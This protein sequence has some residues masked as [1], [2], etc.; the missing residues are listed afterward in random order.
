VGRLPEEEL[1]RRAREAATRGFSAP[2]AELYFEYCRRLESQGRAISPVVL[3]HYALSVGRSR[4]PQDGLEICRKA[5]VPGARHPEVSL[6]LAKL[7]LLAGARR[8]AVEEVDRGLRASPQYGPLGR[9]REELGRR[10]AP[11]IRFLPRKSVLN[12][13]LGKLLRRSS[14]GVALPLVSPGRSLR[15]RSGLRPR[16]ALK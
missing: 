8:L 9:L 7:H 16:P 14:V 15:E 4:R 1:L 13:R 5:Q 2:A 6:C 11:P 10:R 12:V 3:A